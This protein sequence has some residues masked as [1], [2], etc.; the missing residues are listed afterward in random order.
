MLN[1]R[2]FYELHNC[3]ISMSVLSSCGLREA[4]ATAVIAVGPRARAE[5]DPTQGQ[6]IPVCIDLRDADN[7]ST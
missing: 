7:P 6:K 1:H 4:A 2:F 5:E 3:A